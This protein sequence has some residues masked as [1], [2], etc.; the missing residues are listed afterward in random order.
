MEAGIIIGLIAAYLIGSI[1]TA[2]WLGKLFFGVDVRTQGSGNAGATNAMRVLGKKMGLAVL[3][4]DISKGMTAV[5]LA[6]VFSDSAPG[7]YDFQLFRQMLGMSAVIGHIF[8]VFAGFRGGKGIATLLGFMLIT[9]TYAAVVAIAFF[10][11]MLLLFRMVSVASISGAIFFSASVMIYFRNCAEISV[12]FS[13]MIVA[14]VI[15]THQKNIQR[16]LTGEE[17]KVKIF[18]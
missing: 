6:Y 11:L 13:L 18:K 16:L 10:I 1:P 8:P 4:M 2:V 12:P 9:N 5:S 14:L 7:T 3:L 15:I 17:S